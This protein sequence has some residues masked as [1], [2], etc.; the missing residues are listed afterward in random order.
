MRSQPH[1]ATMRS[2]LPSPRTGAR[3]IAVFGDEI[4]P[5]DV[6]RLSSAGSQLV[7]AGGRVTRVRDESVHRERGNRHGF[8]VDLE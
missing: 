5:G 3:R 4:D 2:E 7:A 1:L 6:L 8:S